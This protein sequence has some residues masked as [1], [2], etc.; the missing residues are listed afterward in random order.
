M[1]GGW[2]NCTVLH[3]AGVSFYTQKQLIFPLPAAKMSLPAP[4]AQLIHFL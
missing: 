1:Q 4:K 3:K 2:A